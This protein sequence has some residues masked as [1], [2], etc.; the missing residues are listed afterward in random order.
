MVYVVPTHAFNTM[1]LSRSSESTFIGLLVLT[2]QRNP[3]A[4]MQL[5]LNGQHRVESHD[6]TN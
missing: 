5:L 4:Y 6:N 2:E 1:G 3:L